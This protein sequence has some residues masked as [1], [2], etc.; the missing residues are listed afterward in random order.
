MSVTLGY[1]GVSAVE[2]HLL[3]KSVLRRDDILCW[4]SRWSNIEKKREN[5]EKL[6]EKLKTWYESLYTPVYA[7]S[8]DLKKV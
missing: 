8:L 1:I 7:A 5:S 3:S 6:S 2:A 4:H